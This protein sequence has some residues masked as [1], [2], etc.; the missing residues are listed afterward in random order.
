MKIYS[1]LIS[2]FLSCGIAFSQKADL[3]KIFS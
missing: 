1:F 2:V 3:D